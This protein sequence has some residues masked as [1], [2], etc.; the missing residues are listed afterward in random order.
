MLTA[1]K[2]SWLPSDQESVYGPFECRIVVWLVDTPR[3]CT[4]GEAVRISNRSLP[5]LMIGEV[6]SEA[7][8]GV[9]T[10]NSTY[11]C[12]VTNGAQ[13]KEREKRKTSSA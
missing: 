6:P 13:D 8:A 9:E 2:T 1:L 3:Q 5:S 10:V 7:S 12:F 11:R 4:G